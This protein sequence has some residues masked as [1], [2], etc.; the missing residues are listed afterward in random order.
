[1]RI[2]FL[3]ILFPII[4]GTAS[5]LSCSSQTVLTNAHAHNDYWH[6]RPLFQSLENGFMSVEADCHLI[7]KEMLVAHEKAFT[8]KRRT[9]EKLYLDPLMQRAKENNPDSYRDKSVYK[10]G[11][12]EFILYIDIKADCENF[13]PFLDSVLKNYDAMLTKFVDGKKITGAVRVLVDHCGDDSYVLNSNLRYLSLSGNLSDADK[14]PGNDIM[15]R[16]SFSY[17]SLLQWKGKGEMP[18]EEKQ[19]LK[20]FIQKVHS[21]GYTVRM[22]AAGNKKKVWKELVAAGVDWINVDRL[23]KFSRFSRN[24]SSSEK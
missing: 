21:N 1:M 11:P 10:N 8:K 9:L 5:I 16:I 2:F 7:D 22:W 19:K 13:I 3:L 14:K 15:P 20:D 12:T 24:Y 17:N 23:K 4:I 6:A 18:E